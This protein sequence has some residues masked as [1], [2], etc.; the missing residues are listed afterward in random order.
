MAKQLKQIPQF[1][2]TR[3]AW[4]AQTEI[5]DSPVRIQFEQMDRHA[6]SIC[7]CIQTTISHCSEKQLDP[8]KFARFVKLNVSLVEI[9]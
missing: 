9:I 8:P 3:G 5:N 7:I 1:Y 6:L 4:A 2:I